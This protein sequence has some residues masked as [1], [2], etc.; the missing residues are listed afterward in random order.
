MNI[1]QKFEML[2]VDHAPGQ[3]I[4]RRDEELPVKGEPLP[5]VPVDF[6]HGDVDAHPPIPGALQTFVHG[7]YEGG[8]QAYTEYRERPPSARNWPKNCLG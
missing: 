8:K 4:R 7:F 3:E 1:E 6:S 5:G 2:G